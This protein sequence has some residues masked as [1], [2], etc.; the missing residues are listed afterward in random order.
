MEDINIRDTFLL[1]GP[2]SSGKTTALL[3][4]AEA[5]PDSTLWVMDADNK[6]MKVWRGSFSHVT[7]VEYH[8]VREW[9]EVSDTYKKIR[10]KIKPEDFLAL[11]MVDRYWDMAQAYYDVS[12]Y[13][14]DVGT[15]LLQLKVNTQ[16][17]SGIADPDSL[18]RWNV[19]KRMHNADFLDDATSYLP[20]HVV[21]TTSASTLLPGQIESKEIRDLYGQVGLAANGEKRNGYR[22]DTIILLEMDLASG[23]RFWTTVKDKER[24]YASRHPLDNWWTDY[25]SFV[26]AEA[27]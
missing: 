15:H 10:K 2:P 27:K 21:L 4:I 8:L 3:Q 24:P 18:S 9:K 11:E 23:K 22:V 13:G 12:V 5:N 1:Y 19:I 7:N 6:F 25:W 14:Q 20:C 17:K 16:S 26:H